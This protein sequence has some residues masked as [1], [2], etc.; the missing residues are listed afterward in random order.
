MSE[1]VTDV[2]PGQTWECNEALTDPDAVPPPHDVPLWEAHPRFRA[3]VD[4]VVDDVA[5][6]TVTTGNSHPR[7]PA[8]GAK[9]D[10]HVD[11]LRDDPRWRL[12]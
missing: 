8:F 9:V 12:K 1:G 4:R 2:S 6:L 7:T 5:E 3:V 10:W 11:R